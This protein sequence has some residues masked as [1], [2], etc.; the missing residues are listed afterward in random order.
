MYGSG[1]AYRRAEELGPIE[2][3]ER[4]D[5]RA[6]KEKR[7]TQLEAQLTSSHGT[8]SVVLH[9]VP[10]YSVPS[11]ANHSEVGGS[12]GEEHGASV[13]PTV[14]TLFVKPSSDSLPLGLLHQ[15]K[16]TY[17]SRDSLLAPAECM[18]SCPAC[19]QQRTRRWRSKIE[20][21]LTVMS[22]FNVWYCMCLCLCLCFV[23]LEDRTAGNKR[24]DLL[25]V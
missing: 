17:P 14:C 6:A 3:E 8:S 18:E 21:T 16:C 7:T 9:T 1:P 24:G 22:S 15:K 20:D 10:R 23:G 12:N 13:M 25:Q 5:E 11:E 2:G 19:M 4:K